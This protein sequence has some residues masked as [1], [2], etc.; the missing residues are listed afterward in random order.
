MYGKSNQIPLFPYL[1]LALANSLTWPTISLFGLLAKTN[2]AF[3]QWYAN[4]P[5]KGSKYLHIFT[6]GNHFYLQ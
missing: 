3:V 6:L 2:E 1:P 5:I 4:G